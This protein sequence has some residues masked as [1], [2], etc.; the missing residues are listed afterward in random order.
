MLFMEKATKHTFCMS[1]LYFNPKMK[2]Y[3]V[4]AIHFNNYMHIHSSVSQDIQLYQPLFIKLLALCFAKYCSRQ[5][6]LLYGII[7]CI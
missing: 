1:Y 7:M 6:F 3:C 5:Y 4:Q 2:Y